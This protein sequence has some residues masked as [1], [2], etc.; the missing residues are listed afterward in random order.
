MVISTS[1]H[2]NVNPGKIYGKKANDNFDS[3]QNFK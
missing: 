2:G 3:S 1:V